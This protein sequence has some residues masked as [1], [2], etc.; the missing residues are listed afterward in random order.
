MEAKERVIK[1]YKESIEIVESLRNLSNITWFR[2]IAEGKWSICEVIGHLIYWDHFVLEKR[3][4]YLFLENKKLES[5][6]V[7]EM[8]AK[9]AFESKV[10]IKEDVI[11]EF[12][13]E[14]LKIIEKLNLMSTGE[15][16]KSFRIG[17]NN[18]TMDKY[19]EGLI[20]HDLHHFRQIQDFLNYFEEDTIEKRSNL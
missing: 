20:E 16:F 3:L 2:P 12:V 1:H 7:Q 9:A 15:F 18:L 4:P 17:N 14:R 11:K 8:N 5:V 19:F 10:K 13:E 6:N